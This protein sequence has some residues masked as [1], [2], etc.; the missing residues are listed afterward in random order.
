MKL[1][2][3]RDGKERFFSVKLG[4]RES[5]NSQEIDMLT[6]GSIP[7]LIP[8]LAVQGRRNNILRYNISAY[9]TLEFYLSC[10]LTREQFAE[11]LLQCIDMFKHMQKLYLNYKNLVLDINKI[12]IQLA[13]RTVHFIYLP[14]MNSKREASIEQ[15]FA[16]LLGKAGRS[17][18]EQSA[19]VD[20]CLA[21]LNSPAPFILDGFADY[22]KNSIQLDGVSNADKV[23]NRDSNADSVPK[24]SD[25]TEGFGVNM[26]QYDYYENNNQSNTTLLSPDDNKT[27]LLGA[28][29]ADNAEQEMLVPH[30]Y[31]LRDKNDDKISMTHFPFILGTEMGRVDY[32]ISDNMAVSR[33]H[34]EF[35]IQDGELL[36]SDQG[37]TN[38]TYVNN[39]AIEPFRPQLLKSGDSV[40][41]GNEKMTVF[42]EDAE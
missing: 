5:F 22:I 21:W 16:A 37:S 28:D 30:Y 12:Y 11:L 13:D 38:K 33:R 25:G 39:C 14:I 29:T 26:P 19:F 27:V 34:A 10:I 36:I 2:A 7:M 20:G 40:R 4:W 42:R 31:L 8:P 15:F 23:E 1:N 41:L 3:D 32:C 18:Y 9:S 24:I 35:T 17:T 6:A